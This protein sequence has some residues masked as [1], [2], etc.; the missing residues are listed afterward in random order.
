MFKQVRE[1]EWIGS[2]NHVDIKI[3]KKEMGKG[4]FT[5]HAYKHDKYIANG[6]TL[7]LCKSEVDQYL[8]RK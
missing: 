8:K 1:D 7:E 2:K 5:F 6:S 4:L 3:I